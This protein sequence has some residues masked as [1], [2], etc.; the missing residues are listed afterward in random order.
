MAIIYF[1]GTVSGVP[2]VL[3]CL[4]ARFS[5][6]VTSFG[7]GSRAI[8]TLLDSSLLLHIVDRRKVGAHT[9]GIC[10]SGT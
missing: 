6:A 7:G 10:L 2:L 3:I 1:M 5:E 8:R 4:R 9:E